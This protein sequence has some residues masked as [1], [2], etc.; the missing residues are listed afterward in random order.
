MLELRRLEIEG[1]GPFADR[2]VL[3]FPAEP[4]ITLVYG[5]NMRGKTSLLN[6]VR[7]AFY[8]TV[9]GRGSRER[10]LHAITNRDLAAAGKFGFSVALAFESDGE[11]Y[12]L[13]RECR[14][15]R[16]TPTDD[17]HYEVD[18]LLRQGSRVLGPQQR[19]SVLGRVLPAQVS[20]FF[21]FD[22]EL[23]QEYEELLHDDSE[24]GRTISESIERILGVPILKRARAHLT[25]LADEAAA[26]AA[27][28]AS[29][30]KQTEAF[31]TG[32]AQAAARKEAH[33]K[34]AE[35]L[36][37]VLADLQGR[38]AEAEGLLRAERKYVVILEERD[39]K[40][41]RLTVAREEIKEC[42]A[43][44]QAAMKDAWRTVLAG[45]V[46]AAIGLASKEAG[47]QLDRLA[48]DLRRRAVES[49]HC[50]TCDRDLDDAT[51]RRL[52]VTVGARAA[53]AGVA[54]AVSR[55]VDLN[56]FRSADVTALVRRLSSQL[57]QLRVEVIEI[58]DRLR[59]LDTELGDADTER[60][61]GGTV[62]L[63]DTIRK[64]TVTETA[65]D[66]EEEEVANLE[67]NI[68]KIS[69][70]LAKVAP[71][72]LRGSQARSALLRAAGEVFNQAVEGY[73]TELR[74]QVQGTASDLFLRMTTEDSEYARLEITDNYGLNIIHRDTAVEEGR[75]A[76]AEHVVALALVG[77]L[78]ANAPLRGPIV[79][80]S[81]F[82]RLDEGHTQ[83]VVAA[84]ATMAS[85]VVLLV[86]EAELRRNNVRRILGS[87]LLREYELV[88]VSARRSRIEAVR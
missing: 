70:Q 29:R 23:L 63:S 86:H 44:L 85:Q 11:A 6:A 32:L 14:P 64:I 13:V 66:A 42:A 16:S 50:D 71:A 83:N 39:A 60:L 82:G 9:V 48:A 57:G 40:A 24:A 18:L 37:Q 68:K 62:S 47:E 17:S 5:E 35:R 36:T 19:D 81:P 69:E 54:P 30:S 58:Q 2:Q 56:K 34:E 52:E 74:Q 28:E 87:K 33:K 55:L 21:L 31:G 80:D 72:N 49:G 4:G 61:R 75:S 76:G 27:K 38:K 78:Q 73:K 53:E 10:R 41:A 43:S 25:A 7:F 79:M 45:P 26:A 1:F 12:E 3:E 20:R 77:A 65:L 88:K 22:G 8:G 51:A 59:D 46:Q 15:T 84:L 67:A